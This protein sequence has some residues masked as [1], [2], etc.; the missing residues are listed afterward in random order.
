MARKK[1]SK[2]KN[3]KKKKQDIIF[4]KL[5]PEVANSI[6]KNILEMQMNLLESLS[7][8]QQYNSLRKKEFMLKTKLRNN[9]RDTKKNINKI[10][11]HVPK[12]SGVKFRRTEVK[13]KQDKEQAKIQKNIDSRLGDIKDKLGRMS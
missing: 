9:L 1:H 12:T 6:E 11:N 4:S 5:S 2:K 7:N 10:I 8:M 3:H 13:S